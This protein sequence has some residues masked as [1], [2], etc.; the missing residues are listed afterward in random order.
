MLRFKRAVL[1]AVFSSKSWMLVA[2]I[3]LA[4]GVTTAG[5]A[6]VTKSVVEPFAGGVAF[7]NAGAYERLD[8]DLSDPPSP[9]VN[10]DKAC[11]AGTTVQTDK[12][13]V[14]GIVVSGI[15][16]WQGIPF[17]APPV[18]NLRWAPPQ[19]AAPW[20]G[21]LKATAFASQCMQS[22]GGGEDCLYLNVW[23]PPGASGLSVMAHIH[24]GGFRTGSGA[25]DF[26]LL[27]GTG[28]VVVV[29]LNYRLNI[30]GFAANRAFGPS[31]G[32][33]GLQD[34]QA[35]L[36]WIQRNVSAFGGDP[37]NVTIF[38]ESAGGS[39]VC[40]QIASPTAAGLFHKG[41][42][43]SGQ[44]NTIFE[45]PEAPGPLGTTLEVQ[46]C[47]SKLPSLELAE[48]I[49]DQFATALGCTGSDVAACTRAVDTATVL[50]VSGLGYQY[51]GFGTIAPTING[52]TLVASL[53]ELLER[54]RVNRV[55]VI[56]GTDRDENLAG[57]AD[58][59]TDYANLV[60]AQFGKFA[61][62]VTAMYPLN[63]FASPGIAWRT[64][65]ADAY[66]VCSELRT[67][68]AISRRMPVYQYLIEYAAPW[69]PAYTGVPSGAG[70]V[71]AW[72]LT[73]VL[74]STTLPNGLDNNQQVLQD[75]EIAH[76]SAFART[77]NPTAD[78][79]PIW[80][81]F[82]SGESGRAGQVLSLNA[83]GSSQATAVSEI[84]RV[85]N[86]A[87]WDALTPGGRDD[88]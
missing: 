88:D 32:D 13:T 80:P 42:S 40:D 7:G 16:S 25:G 72:V 50:N 77:G 29:S 45:T 19:A 79:T 66:T 26:S 73:P 27:S 37:H 59:A 75:E 87:F 18:G 28:N 68:R 14:C 62:Q 17:A 15:N 53:A 24:G 20:S 83:G 10:L 34:Q 6:R 78:G 55:P 46:D 81:R 61:S 69:P 4:I 51:D 43:T 52:T 12:G 65:A 5:E 47:K 30:F 38:G 22:S 74:P 21:T 3:L 71:R 64:I 58:T 63:R 44:Y 76:V 67:V 23:A 56:F 60:Q 82:R 2:N 41:I 11:D 31:S 84:R 33:Y 39:S 49:G 86:C 48:S 54:G 57:T 85:H 70:H 36:Q 35:A 1:F 9:M 8:G